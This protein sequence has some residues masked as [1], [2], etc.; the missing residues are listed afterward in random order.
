MNPN[1]GSFCQ[2]RLLNERKSSSRKDWIDAINLSDGNGRMS[3]Y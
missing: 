2:N 3:I 1:L